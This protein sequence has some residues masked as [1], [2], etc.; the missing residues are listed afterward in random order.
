M[1]ERSRVVGLELCSLQN[2]GLNPGQ[3]H[4]LCPWAKSFTIIASL[5]PGV[6]M[7]TGESFG[8]A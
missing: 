4:Y 6:K 5:H 1:A 7:G 8:V 3:W 2:V